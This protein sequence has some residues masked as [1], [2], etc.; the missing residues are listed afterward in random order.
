MSATIK[1]KQAILVTKMIT[2]SA[3]INVHDIMIFDFGGTESSGWL[4]KIIDKEIPN[5]K[6]MN[7]SLK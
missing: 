5:N 3:A 4:K 7:A 6:K 2:N 1:K